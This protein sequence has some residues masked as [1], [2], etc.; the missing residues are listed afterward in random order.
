MAEELKII[1]N[2]SLYSVTRDG[3]VYTH[4][5]HKGWIT[6]NTDKLGYKR[7]HATNDSGER[8]NLYIHRAVAM[9]YISN[10]DNKPH[11]NH[12][13]CNPSNN[14][15]SNLE[16]CTHAENMQ[17]S[18]KLGRKPGMKGEDNPTHKYTAKLINKVRA[19]YKNGYTQMDI[20]RQL[21]IPQ[22]TVSVI[23]RRIQWRHI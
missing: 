9:T 21:G 4:K 20:K 23:V 8:S 7:I 10:P 2:H 3:R 5:L 19:L 11:I 14:D 22:P 12:K 15:I 6:G 1:P 16:W 13:D 17:Y 18:A